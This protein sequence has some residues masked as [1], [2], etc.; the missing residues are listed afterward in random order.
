MFIERFIRINTAKALIRLTSCK[1]INFITITHQQSSEFCIQKMILNTKCHIIIQSLPVRETYHQ[2]RFLLRCL[3][4]YLHV[5]KEKISSTHLLTVN[6]GN[7]IL[8]YS[9]LTCLKHY[10]ENYYHLTISIGFQ[11]KYSV[12]FLLFYKDGYKESIITSAVPN[13]FLP[14]NLPPR[15]YL[16]F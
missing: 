9:L 13:N 15:N 11:Y 1:C 12:T 7:I 10:V 14:N 3:Q 5:A 6:L 4:L 2:S 8:S 16:S